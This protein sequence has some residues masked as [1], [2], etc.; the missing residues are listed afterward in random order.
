[1]KNFLQL[2][3]KTILAINLILGIFLWFLD[4][5]DFSLRGTIPD[6]IFPPLVFIIATATLVL[7]S[8]TQKR[9]TS[10]ILCLPSLIAGGA[11]ILI[12]LMMIIPPFTLALFFS[13]DEI[14]S[15]VRIQQISSPNSNETAEVYFRPVGAYSGGSGRIYIRIIN[16]SLSFVERDIL[17]LRV[18]HADENTKNYLRWIDDDTLY[19]SEIKENIS[20][21]NIEF[22]TPYAIAVPINFLRFLFFIF[23][24]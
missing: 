15:E 6:I 24:D 9:R 8:D 1:M 3:S 14:K 2:H 12:G 19:I 17:Y 18:S 4:S 20:V 11:H 10:R 16:N 13:I 22:E 23:T 21:G 5:T 7:V